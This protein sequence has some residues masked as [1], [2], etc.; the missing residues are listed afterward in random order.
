M[1][2]STTGHREEKR[3]DRDISACV[4]VPDEYIGFGTEVGARI[5]YKKEP[6]RWKIVISWARFVNYALRA[7]SLSMHERTQNSESAERMCYYTV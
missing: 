4:R 3:E 6:A 2:G 1:S 7:A 5:I